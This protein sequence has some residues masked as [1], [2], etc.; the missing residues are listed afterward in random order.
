MKAIYSRTFTKK[1]VCF[2]HTPF[3][4]VINPYLIDALTLD[5]A[6]V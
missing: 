6:H 4:V 3:L 1:G 2:K 5:N